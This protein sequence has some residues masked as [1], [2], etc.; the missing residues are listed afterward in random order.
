MQDAIITIRT[1][2]CDVCKR[3]DSIMLTAAEIKARTEITEMN[4]AAYTIPHTDHTRIVYFDDTGQYLGDTIA[5]PEDELPDMVNSDSIPFYIINQKKKSLF[6]R[7]RNLVANRFISKSLSMTIS[8]PSRAGKTSLVRY[9]QTLLPERDSGKITSVPTMGKS[10]KRLTLGNSTLTTMDMGGQK[11][12]WDLWEKPIAE[13]DVIIFIFDGTSNNLLEVAKSFERVIQ[14]RSSSTPV[15]IIVNKKDLVL[16]GQAIRFAPTAEF[17]A[18][19]D[20]EIPIQDVQAIEASIFEGI[21]YME[22]EE[23]PLA[24]VISSFLEEYC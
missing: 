3:F 1:L 19:T 14:Y 6:T 18:L 16:R 22:N 21:A 2:E 13:S 24:E 15:L 12:F 8:G 17:M 20:L 9:L 10:T 5:Y 7:L 23:I 11:D 4:V